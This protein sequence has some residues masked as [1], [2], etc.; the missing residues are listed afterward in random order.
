MV[1]TSK[2]ATGK[3]TPGAFFDFAE[4]NAYKANQ[5]CD[6]VAQIKTGKVKPGDRLLFTDAWHPGVIQCRYM[7][8]LLGLELS[9]HVMWHAGSYDR[10]DFLGR[11]VKNKGWSYNFERSVFEAADLNY[12][13]TNYHWELFRRKLRITKIKKH[14]LV[15]WPMEYLPR[16]LTPYREVPKK[17]IIFF[18]H[19]IAPEKRPNILRGLQSRFPLFR[20]VFA[21]NQLLTKKQ[22]HDQ[23][24]EAKCVFS[25][26]AQET[27]GIGTYEGLLC[28]AIPIV[29]D[30][31][32]YP[33]MY[34]SNWCYPSN[35]TKK[36][37]QIGV[38]K[39][40]LAEFI[41]KQIANRKPEQLVDKADKVGKQFFDGGALY[42]HLLR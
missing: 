32:S 16:L 40:L 5:V 27:L 23:L 8:D 11:R 31:L 34:G 7:S 38:Q 30:R 26:S 9:I 13:A 3:L 15:G 35:W 12:F 20:L 28:G 6:F 37:Q 19:R 1:I 33:E 4:T 17:D 39:R 22:Y 25:A 14:R 18:P 42:A 10:N 24:G 2:G 41:R 21:Q 29:P 36:S